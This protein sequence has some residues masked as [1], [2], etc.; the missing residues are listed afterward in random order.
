MCR[1]FVS[2]LLFALIPIETEGELE[3]PKSTIEPHGT[4]LIEGILAARRPS[5]VLA[6]PALLE[7]DVHR[8]ASRSTRGPIPSHRPLTPEASHRSPRLEAEKSDLIVLDS[9]DEGKCFRSKWEINVKSLLEM[10]LEM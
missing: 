10:P 5:W 4:E 9:L 3:A 8:P 2:I 7:H 6:M 1:S